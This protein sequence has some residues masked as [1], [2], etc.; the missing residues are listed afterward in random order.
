MGL[1]DPRGELKFTRA[2][3]SLQWARGFNL[4]NPP[5][6]ELWETPTPTYCMVF[7]NAACFAYLLIKQ[8]L[9]DDCLCL[10]DFDSFV[11]FSFRICYFVLFAEYKTGK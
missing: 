4:S 6:F 9:V 7:I 5:Q 2:R 3:G 10:R 11:G 8:V 1:G